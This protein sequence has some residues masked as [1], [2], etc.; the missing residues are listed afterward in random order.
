MDSRDKDKF[1][2]RRRELKNNLFKFL[3][4]KPHGIDK[5]DLWNEVSRNCKNVKVA[6]HYYGVSK[7]HN[8][9][10]EFDDMLYEIKFNGKPHMRVIDGYT[11]SDAEDSGSDSDVQIDHVSSSRSSEVKR[12][13]APKD[14]IVRT[15]NVKAKNTG[16]YSNLF[17]WKYKI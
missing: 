16:I 4:K 13:Q 6:A 14:P 5:H 7:M 15:P 8:L 17:A 2:K 11:P 10:D 9:L 12:V 1:V 3:Q